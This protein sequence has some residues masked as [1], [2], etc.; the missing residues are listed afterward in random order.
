M[1]EVSCRALATHLRIVAGRGDELGAFLAGLG[2]SAGTLRT[3]SERIDWDVYCE[4]TERLQASCGGPAQLLAESVRILE[5]PEYARPIKVMALFASSTSIYRA[6][7]RWFGP[8]MFSNIGSELVLLQDGRLRFQ[9]SIPESDRDCPGFFLLNQGAFQ[10]IPSILGQPDAIVEAA[11]NTRRAVFHITPPPSMTIWSRIRRAVQVVTSARATIDE[12]GAQTR[13]LNAQLKLLE[14]A[15][16]EAEEANKLKDQ[17]LR[18]VSHELRTPLN[19]IIGMSGLILDT[20]LDREQLEQASTVRSAA[21][22][23]LGIVNDIL[24]FSKIQAG[25]LDLDIVDF[26][27]RAVLENVLDMFAEQA[28]AQGVKLVSV[29]KKDVPRVVAGDPGR[30]RQVL[31]NLV[32]N[33]VKFTGQGGEVIVRIV[34]VD[35]GG[36]TRLRFEVQDTGVGISTEAQD[37]IFKPFVQEDGSTTR[38][39]GGTGLGLAIS[40]QLVDLMNGS[41]GVTSKVGVGSTFY[42][43]LSLAER[44]PLSPVPGAGA[45]LSGVRVVIV[46]HHTASRLSLEEALSSVGMRVRTASTSDEAERILAEMASAGHPADIAIVDRLLPEIDGLELARR[47]KAAPATAS[48]PLVLLTSVAQRGQAQEA[49]RAGF[50]GYASKPVKQAQLCGILAAVLGLARTTTDGAASP[51]VTRHTL[52]ERVS[53]KKRV[54]VVEDNPVNQK[55][56][57]RL[58]ERLGFEVKIADNGEVALA[59]LASERFDAV[60]MDCQMPVKDGYDATREIRAR[61]RAA[62]S[63]RLPIIAMTAHAMSGDRDRC[64]ESGMDDYITKPVQIDVLKRT[65]SRW[66]GD[67]GKHD[68]SPAGL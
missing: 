31:T 43:T 1:R 45:S 29:M 20:E 30:V 62:G 10:K 3:A 40:R 60:L 37:R 39:F 66:T 64:M 12:L 35:D 6:S 44:A 7:E 36:A 48:L 14:A 28:E 27:L 15:K 25:K 21:D 59:M 13:Q 63:A 42:F 11:I 38:K 58:V 5:A 49:S 23:L 53:V 19:A 32:G 17:F 33:A 4:L 54:L 18:N 61:E 46:D 47:I 8:S 52:A 57:L 68:A 67:S 55:V 51:I 16:L 65:L 2:V 34:R 41:I 26:D 9:L 24:D 56:A 22:T 50:A